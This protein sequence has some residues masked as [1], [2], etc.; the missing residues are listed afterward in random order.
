MTLWADVRYALRGAWRRPG[1]LLAAVFT[2]AL[3]IGANATMFAV[4]DRLLLRAPAHVQHPD[5][6]V[7]VGLEYDAGGGQRF[8]MQTTSF[9]VLGD[10]Q[11]SARS[12]SALA[13]VAGG[14]MVLGSGAEARA[15]NAAKV[16]GGYFTLLGTSPALGRFFGEAEDQPPFGQ[17]VAVI[18]HALWRREFAGEPRALQQDLLLDNTRFTIIGV[19]P[20]DFTGDGTEAIDV[21]VPLFAGMA[22]SGSG[23]RY[24]RNMRLVEILARLSGN[25]TITA[26]GNEA[27]AIMRSAAAYLPGADSTMRVALSPLKPSWR[28]QA[29]ASTQA[30]VALW[31]AA[32]SV[33]VLVVAVVN[34]VNLLLFRAAARRREVALRVALGA[35]RWQLARQLLLDVM[36]LVLL[37]GGAALL[38]AMWGSEAVRALLMP[39]LAAGDRLLEPRLLVSTAGAATLAGLLAALLPIRWQQPAPAGELRTGGI[40]ASGRP[41]RVP[42]LLLGAQAGLC[43]LLLIGASLFLLSL[44]RVRTQDFGFTSEGLLL[45]RMH[46]PDTAGGPA[47]DALYRE[48]AERVQ[49][50]PGVTMATVIQVAPFSRHHV[51]PI[52]VPGREEFPDETKQA[53]FLN[54]ATPDYFRV[55]GMTL[56]A[57][58]NFTA[59]DGRGA[60]L[61]L[62]INQAMADGLWPGESPLGKCIRV[63]Y[64][65]G[66]EPTGIHAS[67]LVPCREVVGVVN[68]ARPR[69]VREEAGQARM[70]YYVPFGQLPHPPFAQYPP[71][72]WGL[73]IRT[74]DAGALASPVQ[75]ALQSFAPGLPYAEVRP[76]ADL[77]ERQM[78]PWLLGA[79]MFT[80]FGVLALALAAVGLYAVRAYA[81]AQR[82]Q[83]IGV[84]LALGARFGDV[85]RMVLLEGVRVTVAGVAAGAALALLL[86][87]YFEPLLFQTRAANPAVMLIVAGVLVAVAAAASA[88]PAWRAAS[89]DPNVALRAD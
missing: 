9:P 32:M 6:L 28:Q 30:R 51:P 63:G 80:A 36:L 77:L 70:Q 68:N 43:T 37:G 12:F 38:L 34:V 72:V 15:V 64:A 47:T 7:R 88:V 19:T 14:T 59:A 74:G 54:A 49:R 84:R 87:R 1:W 45:A 35:S 13:A 10:L 50:V 61:V 53:P 26:A 40:S 73:L 79:S 62:I 56:R 18:S 65:P 3:G 75:R 67:P 76:L 2:L 5:E 21:W 69:S 22:Q 20:A 16:S 31:V 66:V 42:T 23:W 57:G 89:V 29:G 71:E 86:G 11:A 48:A 39:D 82:T 58:R 83:E 55:L 8:V 81:V 52:A 25:A 4:V 33:V 17:P 24:A 60:Q 85:M 46:F 78:R 44:H 41:T 27:T